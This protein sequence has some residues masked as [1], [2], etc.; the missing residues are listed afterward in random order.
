[1]KRVPDSSDRH[2]AFPTGLEAVGGNL[3]GSVGR[4]AKM[5]FCETRRMKAST[6]NH[7]GG[8]LPGDS[9]RL[10]EEHL[11][12]ESGRI[13]KLRVECESFAEICTDYEECC[14]KLQSLERKGAAAAGQFHDYL[15]MRDQ[16]ERDLRRCL[17]DP[18]ACRKCW[19]RVDQT[20]T[21]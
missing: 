9:L 16:L 15:E 18:A 7:R 2:F 6:K 5:V 17:E 13:A 19:R 20:R 4:I 10:L 14:A 3:A 11:G 1:M 8:C 12:I 21:E